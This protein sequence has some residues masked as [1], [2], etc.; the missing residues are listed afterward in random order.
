MRNRPYGSCREDN[1]SAFC[2]PPLPTTAHQRRALA[3]GDNPH[4]DLVTL[5]T[6]LKGGRFDLWRFGDTTEYVGGLKQC[7]VMS[8]R[9][10]GMEDERGEGLH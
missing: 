8:G 2:E 1:T 9:R 10:E 4:V 3:L 5:K 7:S 6:L